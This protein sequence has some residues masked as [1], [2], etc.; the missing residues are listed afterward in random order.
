MH[1]PYFTQQEICQ[2]LPYPE[3]V[4]QLKLAFQQAI[5]APRRHAHQLQSEPLCNLLLM[6]VWQ[7]QARLG[8]KLVTVAPQNQGLPSVHAIFILFDA[9]T[10]A[11][12]ALMDGEE[13]TKRRTAAA[14]VLAATYL[15]RTDAR[16][17]LLVGN[18]ALSP[19]M[20]AAYIACRPLQKITVWGRNLAKSQACLERIR[21]LVDL[22]KT[23]ELHLSE[24]LASACRNADIICCATTSTQ[25]LLEAD[26]I[27][28]G[29]HLDLVGGFKPDMREA[30]DT[31]VQKSQVFVD[32]YSGALTEAGDLLQPM[33]Q[34]LIQNDHIHAELADLC[35]GHHRGRLND[36]EI[37]LFKSVGTAI[38]DLAAAEMVWQARS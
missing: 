26:W 27:T 1:L 33:Q 20:A 36:H 25:A 16:H 5:Q 19:Y 15:A 7:E 28:P 37:T 3:L 21:Q 13:L 29:C 34:G 24:D 32:T 6:P 30:S 23:L 38:E 9:V 8:V 17:L 22:P 4:T 12:L 10:G 35:R 2:A 31:L 18:G 14:S 11:P